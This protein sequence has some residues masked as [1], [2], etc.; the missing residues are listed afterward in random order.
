AGTT[1]SASGAGIAASVTGGFVS[2]VFQ[3]RFCF[4]L[5]FCRGDKNTESSVHPSIVDGIRSN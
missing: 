1:Y 3:G 2:V 5:V 4:D